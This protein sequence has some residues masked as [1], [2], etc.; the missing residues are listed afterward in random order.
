MSEYGQEV[1]SP[2]STS[3]DQAARGGGAKA[4]QAAIYGSRA[5][6]G[7]VAQHVGKNA[8][9]NPKLGGD[10]SDVIGTPKGVIDEERFLPE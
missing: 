3:G 1:R 2:Y 9:T 5:N 10:A 6:S 7:H 8:M 4:P